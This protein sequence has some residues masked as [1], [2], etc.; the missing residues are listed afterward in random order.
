MTRWQEVDDLG[1]DEEFDELDPMAAPVSGFTPPDQDLVDQ[2]DWQGDDEVDVLAEG[3][4][5]WEPS[6]G[7]PDGY[8]VVRVWVDDDKR[9]TK[10]RLSPSW[11]EKSGRTPLVMAFA[12]SF[13]YINSYGRDDSPSDLLQVDEGE[14]SRP[15]SWEQIDELARRTEQLTERLG[16]LGPESEGQWRGTEAVGES[17]DKLCAIR[18]ELNGDLGSIQFNERKLAQSRVREVTD[19]VVKAHAAA[20]ANFQPAQYEP[21]EADRLTGELQGLRNEA[22]AMMRRGFR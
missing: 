15:F 7:F 22:L 18:L 21:G 2:D 14:A 3:R 5:P 6:H 17:P 16:A 13:T 9:I 10:V 8:G 4:G 20:L 19:A 11:R 12:S 1:L